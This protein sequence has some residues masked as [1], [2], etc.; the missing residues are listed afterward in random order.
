MTLFFSANYAWKVDNVH[1]IKTFEYI[2]LW[3]HPV[4]SLEWIHLLTII[5]IKV[6][7][8]INQGNGNIMLW[9]QI[10]LGIIY[11][12]AVEHCNSITKNT[13]M[14]QSKNKY[15]NIYISSSSSSSSSCTDSMEFPYSL[16]YH[17]SLIVHHFWQVFLTT[18]SVYTELIYVSPCWS[19]ITSVSIR[20][21]PLENIPYG[22]SLLF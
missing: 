12:L 4:S 19:A 9:Q 20:R 1:L 17:L 6:N 7:F 8:F 11:C 3:F 14:Q 18:S 5:F 21:S 13:N 15:T 10:L 2:K 16:S 22:L